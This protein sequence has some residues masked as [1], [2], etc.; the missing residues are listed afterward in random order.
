LFFPEPKRDEPPPDAVDTTTPFSAVASKQATEAVNG[1]LDRL[2]ERDRTL[3]VSFEL[4][5]LSAAEIQHVVGLSPNGV[6]VGLHRARARFRKIFVE[7]YG[8]KE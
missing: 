6:W 4:E 2:S 5:G 3:I 7:L 1:V 8:A